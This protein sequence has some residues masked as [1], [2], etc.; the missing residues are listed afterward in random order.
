M[1][2]LNTKIDI[3][4]KNITIE[5]KAIIDIGCGVGNMT[6]ELSQHNT[7][8]Y[9]IDLPELIEKAKL[10]SPV[11]NE[12]YKIGTAE[13]LSF[14]DN[15]VDIALYFASFHHVPYDQLEKAIRE[16]KRVLKPSGIA[17]FVEPVP[18]K[19]TYFEL[20][21]IT[22]DETEILTKAK[23]IIQNG[24]QFGFKNIIEKYYYLERSLIDFKNLLDIYVNDEKVRE[25]YFSIALK[26][27]QNYSD[28]IETFRYKSICRLN[29]LQDI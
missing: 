4:L 3:I 26:K 17:I 20:A 16:C 15:S 12:E 18:Q 7:Q 6:R 13:N 5:N 24:L 27:T 1:E 11:S 28:D 25:Q 23:N 19:D 14:D 22:G 29:I 2:K 9:G 10:F 21:K 8:I